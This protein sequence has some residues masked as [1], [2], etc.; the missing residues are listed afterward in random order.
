MPLPP[1]VREKDL[2]G[3]EPD[4]VAC[5]N[6]HSSVGPH[7]IDVC[8]ECGKRSCVECDAHCAC[9]RC[10]D[11]AS[12]CMVHKDPPCS[13]STGS[14][15]PYSRLEYF[16]R[17]CVKRMIAEEENEIEE[18]AAQIAGWKRLIGDVE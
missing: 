10:V 6:C 1:G 5:E 15:K 3:F 2:P 17:S 16:R 9:Y 12:L 7:D 8:V 4:S 13:V 18:K 11:D 14:G